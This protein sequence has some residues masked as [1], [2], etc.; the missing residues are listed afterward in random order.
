MS[1]NNHQCWWVRVGGEDIKERS[2][3]KDEKSFR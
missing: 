1:Q 3:A 2:V